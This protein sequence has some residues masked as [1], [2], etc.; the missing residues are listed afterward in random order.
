MNILSLF[1]G[2]SCGMVALERAGIKVDRYVAYEIEKNAVKVS[3]KNYPNIEHM[4]D[5][6][7]ADFTQYIGFDMVIAGFPCQDL[8]INKR[9]RQG[10]NGER[11]GLF[12]ILLDALR[13]IKKR[14]Q[15]IVTNYEESEQSAKE[16]KESAFIP[17]TEKAQI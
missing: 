3:Q 1:D 4:G 2:I 8:P 13:T 14:K 5:V 16:G 17:F 15:T 10:L 9:N 6:K 11:S 7:N 12:W